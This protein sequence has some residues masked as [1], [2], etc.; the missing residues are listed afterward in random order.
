MQSEIQIPCA[1]CSSPVGGYFHRSEEKDAVFCCKGCQVVF[2]ILEAQGALSCYRDHPVY[3]QAVASG[4]ISNPNPSSDFIQQGDGQIPEED[5]QK[6]HLTIHNMW[7]PSCAQVIH[8]ILMREKGV[9]T[10]VVDYST[11]LALLEYTP[12][13]ISKEKIFRTIDRLGY[14]CAPLQDSREKAVSRSLMLR[15]IV[16]AFFSLNVMMFS[17]PIY[18]TYF[19]GGDAEGYA[20]LFAWLSLG[21]SLPVL[22]YSAWPIW[23]R[24]YAALRVGIWGM[25][26]LVFMGS[27]T[28]G[29]LSFYE[30]LNG[31]PYVYFDSLTVIILFVLLGKMIESRAKFSAKDALIRLTCALPRKGRKRFASGVEAFVPIKDIMPGDFLL[32]RMGEK[33]VLDGIVEEGL[34]SCDESL[35]TGEPMPAA[36]EKGSPVL[37]GT[38]LKLGSLTV[39]VTS[40]IDESALSHIINMVSQEIGHKSTYVRAAD[41]IVRW[42]VPAVLCVAFVTGLFCYFLGVADSG[43]TVL[44]TAVIRGV[45]VLLISCPCAIGIAAPLAESYLLNALAKCGILVRNRGCLPYL[46]KETAFVFDKTGTVTVGRFSVSSG[47]DDLT[48][49]EKKALKGLVSKSSHPIAGALYEALICTASPFESIEEIVGKGIQGRFRGHQYFLGSKVFARGSDDHFPSLRSEEEASIITTVYFT[50]DAHCLAKIALGDQI[51]EGVREFIRELPPKSTLLLSGDGEAAVCRTAQFCAIG[52]WKSG[53]MPAEKKAVIDELK[54][55]GEII[56]MMGDGIND[57]PALSGAHVGIAAH[58]AS[59]MSIQVSDLLL[60][61]T[62]FG[63]LSQL[64]RLSLK[65]Q[66]IIK[67]NLFWA[68]FYNCIGLGIAAAGW[69]TPLYAAF[70]M[71][72]SS[73]IVLFNAQRISS[74][75]REA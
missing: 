70:A 53:C 57:A 59:D 3:A 21:G 37:A 9:R 7:C 11:D 25:E 54:K 48:I 39:K 72:M 4:L 63:A 67:Q 56:A 40:I 8:L 55:K 71:V 42:F 24:C 73:L 1:L 6:L 18:A 17:Y 28:A 38:I 66:K 26:L 47:L 34:G 65:G 32:V 15:F 12:R 51:R 27:L 62:N 19:D 5:F 68:F 14:K 29:G 52:Q 16:A 50:K 43:L 44:Q 30:L 22:F 58:S 45:S 13:M 64:R 20:R 35:M 69:L 10:C 74:Q 60:T 61:T 41:R 31:S 46:G 75:S 36:K 2:Q 23:R 33:I 49:E